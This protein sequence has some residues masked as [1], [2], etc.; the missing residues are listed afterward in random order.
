MNWLWSPTKVDA[1]VPGTLAAT[2][3]FDSALIKALN[4]SDRS[5]KS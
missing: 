5:L 1:Q 4:D 2:F 3:Q